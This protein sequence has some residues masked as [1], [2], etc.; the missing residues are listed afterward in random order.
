VESD[1]TYNLSQFE[2]GNKMKDNQKTE[3]KCYCRMMIDAIDRNDDK[4]VKAAITCINQVK[5]ETEQ[6]E[7]K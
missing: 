1:K 7:R 5:K 6:E 2:R 3:L 4:E